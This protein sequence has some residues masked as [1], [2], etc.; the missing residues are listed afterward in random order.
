M[1]VGFCVGYIHHRWFFPLYFNGDASSMQVLA[2]AIFDENSFLP[3]DFSYGNQLVFLRSSQFIVLALMFGQSGYKAFI[4]GS[5]LSIAFWA[6]VLYFFL[7]E[8][9]NSEKK[10]LLFSSLLLIP[11]GYWDVDY[12]LGQQSHLSNV[13]LALG[14]VVST[15]RYILD[16]SNYFICVG[17][18]CL[19]VMSLEAPM[20]GLLVLAPLL[21]AIALMSNTRVFLVVAIY[22]AS[23]FIL[24]YF[25]NKLLVE[26]H[27]LSI[28]YFD[29]LTFKSSNDF[30]ANFINTS[31]EAVGN[32]S[33]WNSVAGKQLGAIRFIVYSFGIIVVIAYF[34]FIFDTAS[35]AIR[36]G[37]IKL[38]TPQHLQSFSSEYLAGF[39]SLTAVLGVA[40]GIFAVSGLNPDTSRHYLWAIFLVKFCLFIAL[41]D[42]SSMLIGKMWAG[43]FV[44]V[45]CLVLSSWL[46]SLVVHDWN[47]VRAI[48]NKNYSEAV[49]AV[50]R[51]AKETG[52]RYIYG[53]DFW[54][55]MPLNTLLENINAQALVLGG[56]ELRPYS[57]LTRPSWSCVEGTVLY[58]LRDGPVDKAIETKLMKIRGAKIH[59]G[60]SYSIWSGPPVW[61][62][63]PTASCSGLSLNVDDDFL[64]KLPSTVGFV[65]NGIRITSDQSGF[66]VYGPY[67]PLKAGSYYLNVYGASK[68]LSG[69]YVDVASSGG[70]IVH[71]R[72][73]ILQSSV[74]FL[75]SDAVVQLPADV[76]DIEVRVWVNE[77]TVIYLS[78]YSLKPL[79]IGTINPAIK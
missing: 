78:G 37:L 21:V 25:A 38:S 35:K 11:L 49:L 22:T 14:I 39:V 58:Y 23:A 24:A 42:A 30:F 26:S 4:L 79:P 3:A 56:G 9:F 19:F 48:K 41:Y 29:T 46:A 32:I 70:Q 5:S 59:D 53:E 57:W 62:I 77:K 27:P 7:S 51:I 34:V 64:L 69:A 10:G 1:L 33:S 8:Y 76:S 13:V 55:M 43:T 44:F 60:N 67:S 74:G 36:L 16:K 54:R 12:V 31:G 6:I 66:L 71:A 68:A 40:F 52:I 20:R 47:T 50:E 63:P 15:Y 75:L 18:A 65:E 61:Q 73:D 28:N 17:C 72:F 45:I 2:S